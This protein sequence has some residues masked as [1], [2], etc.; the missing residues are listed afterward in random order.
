[1][2]IPETLR[3]ALRDALEAN[4][5]SIKNVSGGS[6]N[7]SA[8]IV[9]SD[10][11]R[12]FLKWNT[13]A[14]PLMFAKE[15]KGLGFLQSADTN[16]RV[17]DVFATG[18]T[19]DGIGWLVQ[20]FITEGRAQ[21]GSAETFGK[22]LAAL[23]Q[24]HAEQFGL[25][26][27]NFIGRLPQSN[28]WHDHWVD[29]FIQERMEPQLKMAVDARKFG[30][31]TLSHF[32]A[33]YKQLPDIFPDELP[34][35]LHGDLWGGNYFYDENGQP[36]IYDPA[37]YYGHREIEL[38]FTHLFGGFSSS[39]YQSYEQHF[40]LEPDFSDRKDIYNLYPLLVHTNLFGGSYARQVQSIVQRF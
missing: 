34:S 30:K 25:K 13:R 7:Q 22:G 4:I 1:M 23:H 28:N 32:E 35:L 10:N 18:E 29:F 37:V 19:E 27:D 31:N 24:H 38:A 15:Q 17:P 21:P 12:C 3:Q 36:C 26:H 33:M 11:R 16:L 8:Q 6:I 40:P 20:E 2:M 5:R 14:E 9:L 39:F